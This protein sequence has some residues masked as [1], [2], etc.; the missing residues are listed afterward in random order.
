MFCFP[1]S[2]A[3]ESSP[4][5]HKNRVACSFPQKKKSVTVVTWVFPTLADDGLIACGLTSLA[6]HSSRNLIVKEIEGHARFGFHQVA[7]GNKRNQDFVPGRPEV[8]QQQRRDRTAGSAPH[9]R[10]SLQGPQRDTQFV[11]GGRPFRRRTWK[12]YRHPTTP[13]E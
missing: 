4:Q 7:E 13:G 8:Q 6:S 1:A 3:V 11:S 10:S 5:M 12:R 2:A 9:L